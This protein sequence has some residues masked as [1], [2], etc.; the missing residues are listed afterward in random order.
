MI[1]QGYHVSPKDMPDV[2]K[3]LH[4]A[5]KP[6]GILYAS[7]KKGA[8]E[9]FSGERRFTDADEEYLKGILKDGFSILKISQGADV[10]PGRENDIWMNVFARKIEVT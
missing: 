4:R 8:G 2:I 10:R 9:C 5:L 1:K 6:E 3:R 7:F